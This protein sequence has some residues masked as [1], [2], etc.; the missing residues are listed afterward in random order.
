ML[1]RFRNIFIKIYS[2]KKVFKNLIYTYNSKK[3]SRV[4]YDN[5]FCYAIDV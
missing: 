3:I 1:R 4:F 2:N 5:I